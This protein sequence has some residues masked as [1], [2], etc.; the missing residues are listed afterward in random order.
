METIVDTAGRRLA[1]RLRAERE[2]R[3]WSAAD[4]AERAGVSRAMIAKVETGRSSPTA[5]LLGKLS[6]AL[7]LTLSALLARAE[8]GGRSR[9]VRRDHQPV[10]RD[11]DGGYLRR[12]V[13]PVAGSDMPVDLVRVELPAGAVVAFPATTFAFIRQMIWILDGDLVFVEGSVEHHLRA[14]DGLEL[15]P[16]QDCRFENR[17][18]EPCTYAVVVLRGPAG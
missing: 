17:A 11:P 10:W 13:F 3:G 1:Q 12:Q 14:G 7:G 16:P 6:G 15:G 9:L 8:A 4:L 2:A 5:M 18:A